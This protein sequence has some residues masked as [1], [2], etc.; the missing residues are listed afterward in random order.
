MFH[1]FIYLILLKCL[2][3]FWQTILMDNTIA[4]MDNTIASIKDF[5]YISYVIS[6]TLDCIWTYFKFNWYCIVLVNWD[7]NLYLYFLISLCH[8]LQLNFYIGF[9]NLRFD[10]DLNSTCWSKVLVVGEYL[11]FLGRLDF[12]I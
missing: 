10:L 9:Y 4:L 6:I 2:A 3:L 5:L 12:L 7:C 11:Y 8:W 1:L